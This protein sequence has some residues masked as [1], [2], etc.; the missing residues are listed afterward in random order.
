MNEFIKKED[1]IT[2]L[3]LK[4]KK[5]AWTA[6]FFMWLMGLS[7]INKDWQ[8]IPN[9]TISLKSFDDILDYYGNTVNLNAD[10]YKN[11]PSEGPFITISNHPFGMWDGVV[12]VKVIGEK[13]PDIKVMAYEMLNKIPI[14]SYFI[15]VD[16]FKTNEQTRN[17][18]LGT[19]LALQQLREGRPLGIFPAGEVSFYQKKSKKV[20][21][22]QWQLPIIKLIQKAKVPIV[23]V[24]FFGQNS[25]TFLSL[26]KINAMLAKSFLNRE[27]LNKTNQQFSVSIGKPITVDEQQG[28]TNI[29]AYSLFLRNKVY[30][31][32]TTL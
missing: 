6:S 8:K 29:E 23:P 11:L 31:L 17:S 1:F 16:P 15:P 30:E 21:D 9:K 2:S 18:L 14:G 10:A 13:R 22:R 3:K 19:K 26:G 12:L 27:F 4:E 20:E 25:N 24:Y 7:R 5:L 32:E 28:F